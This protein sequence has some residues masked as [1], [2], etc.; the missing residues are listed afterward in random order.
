MLKSISVLVATTLIPGLELRASI[1]VGFFANDIRGS[2]GIWGVVAICL[3]ANILLGVAVFSLMSL[4]ENILRR[5]R[6][7]DDNIWPRLEKR[8]E[9]LRPLIE[10]YGVW[11]VAVF[12]GVPLPGTGA[13]TGAMGAYLLKLDKK[14]FWL[15]NALG[16]TIAAIAVTAICLFIDNGVVAEDSFVRRLFLKNV[17]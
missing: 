16:V 11:G 5:W 1:P 12:I 14:R 9:K 4:A 13:Y 6:W 3:V 10:K 2:L 8:Q 7:F 17:G 15:A